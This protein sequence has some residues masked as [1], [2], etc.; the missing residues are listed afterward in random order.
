M[1]LHGV[2]VIIKLYFASGI[3]I[4][5]LAHRSVKVIHFG[6]K[7]PC[8]ALYRPLIVAFDLLFKRFGDTAGFIRPRQLSKCTSACIRHY[9]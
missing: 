7:G 9:G 4:L 2:G 3:M 8:T 1:T 6:G 5:N